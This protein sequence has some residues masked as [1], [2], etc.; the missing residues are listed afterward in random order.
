M[1]KNEDG[2]FTL[3]QEEFNKMS[4]AVNKMNLDINKEILSAV[5]KLEDD[6]DAPMKNS[7]AMMALLG[8]EPTW[9]CCGFNYEGQP[10]YKDHSLG[11]MYVMLKNIDRSFSVFQKMIKSKFW[12]VGAFEI[13]LC[14]CDLIPFFSLRKAIVRPGYW[15]TSTSVHLHELGATGIKYLE[16]M[17]LEQKE[18]FATRTLLTDTN[19]K[20]RKTTSWQYPGRKPW[21][22]LKK[23]ILK[24]LNTQTIQEKLSENREK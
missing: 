20:Y 18:D 17:L 24:N 2:T 15:N 13:N 23:N 5:D 6:I 9:C 19:E 7:I 10:A 1:K 12:E 21:N 22:I 8:M 14:K 16:Q 3:T 4:I 11:Y